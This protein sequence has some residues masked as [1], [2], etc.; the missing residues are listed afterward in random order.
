VISKSSR[1]FS[2]NFSSTSA[3][4]SSI[5]PRHSWAWSAYSAGIAM[6]S[7]CSGRAAPVNGGGGGG[8][9]W[10]GRGTLT[11]FLKEVRRF[12]KVWVQTVFT[13]LVTTTLYL[14][15]FGV[16]LGSLL[17]PV[18]GI[19][20]LE[21]VVPGL[22]VLAMVNAAYANTSSSLFQSKI[23]GTV[24]DVLVA[25]LGAT[26]ILV[27]YVGAAVVRAAIVGG[28]VLGVSALFGRLHLHAPFA[29]AAFALGVSVVFALLGLVSAVLA[30]KFEQMSVVP[31]FVLAPL[32][33]LGGVFYSIHALPEPWRSVS[34]FNPILYMVNGVRWGMLG[35]SD[36]SPAASGA[37]VAGLAALLAVATGLL[38]ASGYKLRS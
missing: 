36:V 7:I 14:L 35:L 15:V 37:L 17:R 23:N 18:G 30:E 12:R 20:Y 24:I 25:P 29:T 28:L 13:P 33:Y 16:A 1:Y 9:G 31:S 22:V 11:L 3:T 27:A 10:N 6:V 38:L 26:E 5:F 19:P 2:S 8:G 4:A 34:R 32:T 21:F